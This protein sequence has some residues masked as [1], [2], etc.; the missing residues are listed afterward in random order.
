MIQIG[1][2]D[3]IK[4]LYNMSNLRANFNMS[5]YLLFNF[6]FCSFLNDHYI[7]YNQVFNTITNTCLG[8]TESY[9]FGSTDTY[10]NDPSMVHYL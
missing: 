2:F 5:N 4:T 3:F 10:F 1:K 6:I 8:V 7:F 9:N